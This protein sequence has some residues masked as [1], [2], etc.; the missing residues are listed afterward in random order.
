MR[1][2]YA[3]L[4]FFLAISVHAGILGDRSLT[5]RCTIFNDDGSVRRNFPGVICIFLEDGSFLS[6]GQES[7]K[8]I[9]AN[10]T[11]L[12]EIPGRYHHQLAL[13]ED[14]TKILALSSQIIT[15]EKKKLLSDK[16]QIIDLNG[17]VLKETTTE[18]LIKHAGVSPVLWPVQ[19]PVKKMYPVEKEFSHFNSFYEI[20]KNKSKVPYLKEGNFIVNSKGQ[21]YWILS[22]ELTILHS[23]KSPKAV[24]NVTHDL[25]VTE[26]GTILAFV[27]LTEGSLEVGRYSTIIEFT[28]DG[29]I[30]FEFT[31]RPKTLFYARNGGSV[32]RLD[33]DLLMISD[34]L[35]GV[36]I[37]S[38]SKKDVI[39]TFRG[40]HF[41]N[42]APV[43]LIE[44][45][46]QDV[47]QFMKHRASKD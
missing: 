27:N 7:L 43:P 24:S 13:T 36:Y 26:D 35:N 6:A 25:Q 44:T 22:P 16:L 39:H 9:S 8:R 38:R 14:R 15:W 28:P 30:T 42:D 31:A 12:W 41:Q 21:G 3:F 47:T 4:I 5:S 18:P 33:K 29:K 11:I 2:C 19:A 32:Q 46:V 17:K 45:R 34:Y 37:Y 10:D 40:A 1:R 23:G 20:P